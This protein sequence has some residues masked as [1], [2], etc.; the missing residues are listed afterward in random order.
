[1]SAADVLQRVRL[2]VQGAVQGVGY[3]P[4][5]YRLATRLDLAG[6]II[7]DPTGVTIEAEG[8]GTVLAAF[9][10]SLRSESPPRAIVHAV[11][12]RDI[13]PTGAAG[14]TIRESGATGER[15]TVVLPDT[16]TCGECMVEVRDARDR[17]ASYAFT[18]CTNCGP[19]FSI[20]RALPYDRPNTTMAGFAMCAAC[21]AEYADPLDRRFHA[22]PNACAE[23]GPRLALRDRFG[24]PLTDADPVAAAAAALRDG[25]IVAVK[26]IGGFHLLVDA[27]NAEAV[28]MLRRR[29][30]RPAK[31]FAVMAA[32]VAQARTFVAIDDVAA[33]L[34]ESAEAPIVL[35]RRR[36]T[37]ALVL[38]D[39]IAPHNP[40]IGVMLPAT[41]L[42]HLLLDSFGG[43]VVATSGNLS[44]E[45][46]CTDEAEAVVRLAGIADLFLVHDRPIERHVDDSVAAII[47]G[48][49]RLLRRAR[50]YAPLP[51]LLPAPVPPILAVGPHMKNT[52]A[53]SRGVQAFISQHI[54]E[55]DAPESQRA[56]ARVAADFLRLYDA[57]PVAIAHDLHPDYASTTWAKAAAVEFGVPALGVQH[58]HAHMAACMAENNV[59]EAV[60]GV[61]WD[62]TGYGTD[63]TIWGGELLLGDAAGYERVAHLLPFRLPGGE[64]A[65]REP[66]RVAAAL[67][68]EALGEDHVV[69]GN[70][71]ALNVFTPAQRRT[72]A[73]MLRSGL[74]APVTTSAGR[75]F[76]GI[77]A[78]LGICGVATFEGEAAIRLEHAA[79]DGERG[80]YD[81]PALT[82]SEGAPMQLD[83]RPLLLALLDDARR[84]VAVGVIAARVH[85]AMVAAM[86]EQAELAGC[87]RVALTG[88]CFQNR[89][90]T[91]RAAAALRRRGFAVLQHRLVPPNDGGVSLGQIVI[92][93]ARL[94]GAN[95]AAQ[96]AA[97][98]PTSAM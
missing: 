23:C 41:P 31:P 28:A 73:H 42:H 22:Q 80:A 3:R 38:P 6:W 93:S 58:H 33:A 9:V 52:V 11:S 7:N 60:L 90:L 49:P 87:G 21:A 78:L 75:L 8:S 4:F 64:A 62:G 71:P 84:G 92:A 45:P 70:V 56:F 82:V 94:R 96:N 68:Y 76:D 69:G 16:A 24:E 79:D 14:F 36:V 40:D 20:V 74:N 91:E 35:L 26:G 18:N 72:L 53:L 34:L 59:S 55:L 12:A 67:L 39:A 32:S 47:D 5:V 85:N 97:A 25:A 54:G 13:P 86:V 81:L 30:R 37:A 89:L 51:V 46:I 95:P 19:R 88:G 61:V 2:H 43:P 83:W 65:V 48:E 98:A 15:T 10:G 77:A 17:R 66:R 57:K 1:M 50:G 44:E 29:K 27:A 63:G